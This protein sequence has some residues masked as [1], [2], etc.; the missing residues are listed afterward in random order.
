MLCCGSSNLKIRFCQSHRRSRVHWLSYLLFVCLC[1]I[2]I[3][4]SFNCNPIRIKRLWIQ[5][6]YPMFNVKYSWSLTFLQTSCNSNIHFDGNDGR[7]SGFDHDCST[8]RICASYSKELLFVKSSV[9][10]SFRTTFTYALPLFCT[11]WF[12]I[13][14]FAGCWFFNFMKRTKLENFLFEIT[15]Y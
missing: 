7:M 11:N 14:A 4:V 5:F 13:H 10:N 2:E 8:L 15:T 3:H 6:R 1:E 12:C 9:S